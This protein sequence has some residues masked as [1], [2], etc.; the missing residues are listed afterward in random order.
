MN[1]KFPNLY[2][3]TYLLYRCNIDPRGFTEEEVALYVSENGN[4]EL[5]YEAKKANDNSSSSSEYS[6]LEILVDG[7]E[8]EVREI[9]EDYKLLDKYLE[10]CFERM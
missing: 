7:E 4:E 3:A 9:V 1:S 6:D 2:N 5:D 8:S 10:E